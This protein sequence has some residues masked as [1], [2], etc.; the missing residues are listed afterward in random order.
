V[1]RVLKLDAVP[2]EVSAV[3]DSDE[4]DYRDAFSVSLR[5]DA[6]PLSAEQWS[7]LL[8]EA[9]AAPMRWF[10]RVGWRTALGLKLGPIGSPD[11]VLG[12][13]IGGRGPGWVRLEQESRLLSASLVT[14]VE[15][16]RLTQA[17]FVCYKSRLAP[18]IWYPVSLL[19]RHIVPH[20]LGRATSR[21]WVPAATT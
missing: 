10:L 6:T 11:H 12:W 5:A 18:L 19:H 9:P 20:L 7:R 2:P 14:R 13:R 3:S 16:E 15:R 4:H 1:A 17:T 8:L 21:A